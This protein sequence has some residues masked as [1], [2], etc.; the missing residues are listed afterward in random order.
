MQELRQ[1]PPCGVAH[2][3]VAWAVAVNLR[4]ISAEKG[5]HR[6]E[7]REEAEVTPACVCPRLPRPRRTGFRME[8]GGARPLTGK[9]PLGRWLGQSQT[10]PAGEDQWRRG[11]PASFPPA[12]FAGSLRVGRG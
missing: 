6:L 11:R 8:P 4:A 3:T 7:R 1:R 10:E 2:V 9:A 12:G 5:T